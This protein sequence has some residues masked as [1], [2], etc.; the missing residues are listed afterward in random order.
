MMNT[1]IISETEILSQNDEKIVLNNEQYE[2]AVIIRPMNAEG[3]EL[4]IG[5]VQ[6]FEN[7]DIVEYLNS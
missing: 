5:M 1:R 6:D 3:S 2:K 7:Q 4:L